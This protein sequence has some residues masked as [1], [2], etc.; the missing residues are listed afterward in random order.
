[1][2][3]AVLESDQEFFAPNLDVEQGVLHGVSVHDR[4]IHP[5]VLTPLVIRG[6]M[7]E[8]E[9]VIG[10]AR[11]VVFVLP[12]GRAGTFLNLK[13]NVMMQSSGRIP[14]LPRYS[15]PSVGAAPF[16]TCAP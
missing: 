5:L 12:S 4:N 7:P 15:K 11:G 2:G 9:A 16:R 13:E 6:V 3:G 10:A 14:P 1:M 8:A